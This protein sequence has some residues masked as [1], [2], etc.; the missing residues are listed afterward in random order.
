MLRELGTALGETVIKRIGRNVS[1]LQE[2]TPLATDV[3]ESDDEFIVIVDAPGAEAADIQ[4]GYK[5]RRIHIRI[6]RYRDHYDGFEM[7]YPGRGLSLEG[8]A[9]L[10]RNAMVSPEESTATVTSTGTLRITLPKHHAHE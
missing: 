3:L 5:R 2:T 4:V 1:K 10:P 7:R 9:R 6:D 8:T